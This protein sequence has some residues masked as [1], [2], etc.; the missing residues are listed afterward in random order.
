MDWSTL[1]SVNKKIGQIGD[2]LSTKKL[3]EIPYSLIPDWFRQNSKLVNELGRPLPLDRI[4]KR[5]KW[6]RAPQ[7]AIDIALHEVFKAIEMDTEGNDNGQINAKTDGG[8]GADGMPYEVVTGADE[9]A[10]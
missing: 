8:A 10:H 3:V 4:P 9:R 1:R 6:R 7:N 2:A 5:P